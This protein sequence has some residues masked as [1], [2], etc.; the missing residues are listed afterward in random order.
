MSLTTTV[1]RTV[2]KLVSGQSKV[3]E[4]RCNTCI[5]L[6]QSKK[7]FFYL[8]INNSQRS[9]GHDIFLRYG[10]LAAKI[11]ATHWYMLRNK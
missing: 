8:K 5:P 2:S 4:S 3:F 11:N 7:L 9:I 1:L 10:H 6:K